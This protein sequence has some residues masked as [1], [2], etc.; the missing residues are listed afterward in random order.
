MQVEVIISGFGGQGAL[1]AGQLLAYSAMDQGKH[2]TWLPSYG[3]EMRGGTAHCIVIVS[4]DPIGSPVIRNPRAAIV[5]N[6]PSMEK[7]EPLVKPG[8]LLVVNQSLVERSP[9]RDD[10]TT[11]VIPGNELAEA[12]GDLRMANVVLL[13]ALLESLPLVS[14]EAVS[15]AL[16]SHLPSRHRDLLEAN[17]KALTRGAEAARELPVPVHA[18]QL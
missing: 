1:F 14:L 8:G 18:A 7:Y 9:E 15:Q 4:D 12:C 3:P 11:L 10:I 17:A 2:V 6:N 13:G 16:E 5:M